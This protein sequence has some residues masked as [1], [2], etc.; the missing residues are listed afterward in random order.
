MKAKAELTQLIRLSILGTLWGAGLLSACGNSSTV[1]NSNAGGAENNGDSE[2]GTICEE[3]KECSDGVFCNG[4]ERCDP[5]SDRANS[6]GCVQEESPCL[7][8][9]TC[10]EDEGRCATD[11]AVTQDADEDGSLAAECGG[12]DCDDSDADRF[13]GNPEVC[14]D[15]HL[16]EDCDPTTIGDRDDDGDGFVASSCC[17]YD[18]DGEL[19]CGEDC[20]DE[21]DEVHPEQPDETC[22]EVDTDCDGKVDEDVKFPPT[23]FP[24]ADGDGYG[25]MSRASIVR[26]VSELEG[27]SAAEAGDCNDENPNVYPAAPN[28]CDG[29]VNHCP[30]NGEELDPSEDADGD[31]H[32][33]PDADCEG[34]FKKDDCDDQNAARFEDNEEVCDG[35]DNNCNRGV[36]ESCP[37]GILLGDVID[38]NHV[39]PSPNAALETSLCPENQVAVGI[40][41]SQNSGHLLEMGVACIN[42]SLSRTDVDSFQLLHHGSSAQ[43]S[44]L[45]CP[46]DGFVAEVE[47]KLHSSD[48][49]SYSSTALNCQQW[50]FDR[51]GKS[52]VT[53]PT[54][55]EASSSKADTYDATMS[56]PV[57]SMP[58]GTRN[59][60]STTTTLKRVEGAEFICQKVTAQLLPDHPLA[61]AAPVETT[62]VGASD[63]GAPPVTHDCPPGQALLG[64]IVDESF[65]SIDEYELLCGPVGL[66]SSSELEIG[67]VPTG[68]QLE[69]TSSNP[70]TTAACSAGKVLTALTLRAEASTIEETSVECA[71]L[72]WDPD[73][74]PSAT[75]SDPETTVVQGSGTQ[76]PQT[77]S[78]DEGTIATGLISVHAKS[79]GNDLLQVGLRCSPIEFS[80]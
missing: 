62:L 26:C 69:N 18:P 72:A 12:D 37:V 59:Y 40:Q 17:N 51:S 74:S 78:C 68:W 50:W 14:D 47:L 5:E 29:L 56:C 45:T 54:F 19:L 9:Q 67:P 73:A 60:Y 48:D 46:G 39:G 80:R 22:D 75:L 71:T 42:V 35:L 10:D 38:G 25:D 30:A 57:G 3:D 66:S 77:V 58:V 61:T 16:D 32:A 36:D 11:C 13:P 28:L 4:T 55:A 43:K 64:V 2:K 8:S 15:D 7:S 53:E 24:D 27:F 33:P 76:T 20:D 34:G 21:R 31:K 70:T 63:T 52:R 65:S 41:A 1:S 23:W 6:F 49:G 44:N 79:G